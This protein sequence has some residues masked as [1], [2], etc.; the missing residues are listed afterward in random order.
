MESGRENRQTST[1]NIL[2]RQDHLDMA[3]NN[4]FLH[5]CRLSINMFKAVYVIIRLRC[6]ILL[7]AVPNI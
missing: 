4:H 2:K 7:Y 3:V 5:P 6:Y 1:G